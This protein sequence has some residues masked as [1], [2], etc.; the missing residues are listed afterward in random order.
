MEGG[1]GPGGRW[2]SPSLG[3][4][5]P[6]PSH[7]DPQFL[8]DWAGRGVCGGWDSR[9]A[10]LHLRCLSPSLPTLAPRPLGG[11]RPCPGPRLGAQY[12]AEA[13]EKLQR[14][15]LLVESVR[16]EKVDLSN[17]LE[18]E[19]RY[20]PPRA[21][22]WGDTPRASLRM[23]RDQQAQTLPPPP[24]SPGL[25]TRAL[26]ASVLSSAKWGDDPHL[27]RLLGGLAR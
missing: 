9:P 11:G 8:P 17:Q 4:A 2:T 12:V 7:L 3:E 27:C 6:L 26:Q 25:V 15:R 20:V 23:A 5:G 19:R 24:V 22:S 1:A 21:L 18:E 13:E 10:C 16:K 14:A